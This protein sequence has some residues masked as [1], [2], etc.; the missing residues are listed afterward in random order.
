M[1]HKGRHRQVNETCI[2]FSHTVLCQKAPAGLNRCRTLKSENC[3]LSLF[4]GISNQVVS[5]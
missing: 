1:R 3:Y 5:Q 2:V 4:E